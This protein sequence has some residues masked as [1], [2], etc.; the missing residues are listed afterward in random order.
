[1]RTVDAK[2]LAQDAARF[3]RRI[4][5]RQDSATVITLSGDLGAGKTSF[6]QAFAKALG[7]EEVVTS[8]TFVIEKIYRLEEQRFARLIH[9]DAYRLDDPHE[10]EPLGF[11]ELLRDP[12]NL[13]L[14]EWPEKAGSLVPEYAVKIRF[15][16]VGEKRTISIDGEESAQG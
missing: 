10:L 16:I 11:D 4:T 2:E 5:P 1:M 13:I 8:P 7:V 15:D 3:A 6:A 9:I 14:I 12:G